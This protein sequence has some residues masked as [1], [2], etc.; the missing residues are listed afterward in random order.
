MSAPLLI[1]DHGRPLRLHV[2]SLFE[3]HGGG[4]LAGAALG[5]QAMSCAGAALSKAHCWDRRDLRLR[6]WHSGPGVVDALEFVTRCVSRGR[7]RQ[8][9]V[10]GAGNC[11]TSSAFRFEVESGG[12]LARLLL[13]DG[14]VDAEFFALAGIAQRSDREEERLSRLKQQVAQQVLAR[15]AAELFA[16]DVI[17]AAG[18]AV[19]A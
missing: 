18:A 19:H 5:F 3:Y 1:L 12:Q 7:Y 2:E 14:M 17:G 8:E 9:R 15:P 11:A 10:D 13:R 4:A 6:S 16:L